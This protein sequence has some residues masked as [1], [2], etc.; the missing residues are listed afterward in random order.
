MVSSS[1]SSWARQ[2]V[3]VSLVTEQY[4]YQYRNEN[5]K[6]ES[7][8]TPAQPYTINDID[9]KFRRQGYDTLAGSFWRVNSIL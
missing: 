9:F 3:E 7:V 4:R 8:S 1:R 6:G 5:Y 2:A